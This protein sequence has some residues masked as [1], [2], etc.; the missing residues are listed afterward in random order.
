MAKRN[1]TNIQNK[2]KWSITMIINKTRDQP[3][4]ILKNEIFNK[5]YDV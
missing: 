3:N 1:K 4:A 5:C 2:Y